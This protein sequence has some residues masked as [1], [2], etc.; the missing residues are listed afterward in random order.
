MSKWKNETAR[1]VSSERTSYERGAAV[2]RVERVEL[3]RVG[4]ERARRH[5]VR[6][7]VHPRRHGGCVRRDGVRALARRRVRAAHRRH[8]V[9]G[10][11][12]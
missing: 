4:V 8:E 12:W 5:R 6:I 3:P 9:R 10:D 7:L 2:V 11:A 1:V